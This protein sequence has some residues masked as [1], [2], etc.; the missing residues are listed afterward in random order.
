MIRHINLHHNHVSEVK[1]SLSFSF[2]FLFM[3]VRF[4]IAYARALCC[5]I[6]THIFLA[7]VIPV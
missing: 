4:L 6:K 2:V 1:D 7:L 5:P 3:T